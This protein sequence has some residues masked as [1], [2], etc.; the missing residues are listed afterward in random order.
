MASSK[1]RGMA[2]PQK[3]Q[4]EKETRAAASLSSRKFSISWF[5]PGANAGLQK[6]NTH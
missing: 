6:G 2:D 5:F 4:T 3:A 1:V